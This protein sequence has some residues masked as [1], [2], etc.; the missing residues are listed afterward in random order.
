MKKLLLYTLL[1]WINTVYSQEL[2]PLRAMLESKGLNDVSTYAYFGTRCA[3]LFSSSAYYLKNNGL[4]S[5]A[6]TVNALMYKSDT[7]RNIALRLDITQKKSSENIEFQNRYFFETYSNLI[8]RNKQVF[9][10]AFEGQILSDMSVCNQI[11]SAYEKN[12]SK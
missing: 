2:P 6:S 1:F 9:N 3:T 10:N 4:P 7:F 11:F 5:D 12:A 8:N